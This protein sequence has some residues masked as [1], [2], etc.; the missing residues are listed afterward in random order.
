MKHLYFVRHGLSEMNKKKVF[1][2]STNTALSDEGRVQARRA[3]QTAKTLNIDGI[4]SSPL[5]RAHET[6]QI[7]AKQINYPEEDIHINSLLT[8]RHFGELE[9]QAWSPD[10]NLDGI[11]DIETVDT[12][13][14]RAHLAL[15]WLRSLDATTVLVVSHGSF[16]RALRSVISSE[17]DYH[18]YTSG[19]S[20][21][22]GIPN[23]EILRFI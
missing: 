3:G 19:G 6:A 23:A 11:V 22:D 5:V 15:E 9:G 20:K 18:N 1:A 2:G 21:S 7:I 13:I 8:E 12:I 4:V 10:L 14:A 17:H 16:G